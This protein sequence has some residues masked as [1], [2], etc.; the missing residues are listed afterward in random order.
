M[1]LIVNGVLSVSEAKDIDS[2][3]LL[4]E[5]YFRWLER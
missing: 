4:R 5:I 1:A 3:F 2:L